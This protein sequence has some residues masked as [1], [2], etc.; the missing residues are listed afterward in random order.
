[1][2]Q[3]HVWEG[4]FTASNQLRFQAHEGGGVGS[5]AWLHSTGTSLLVSANE[6]NQE[7]KLW[8]L[9]EGQQQLIQVRIAGP[10]LSVDIVLRV[11]Y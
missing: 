1:M 8:T 7:V 9:K 11:A 6:Q 5:V 3:V 10:V 4:P 2:A